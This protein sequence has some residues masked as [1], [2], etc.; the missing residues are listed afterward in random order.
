MGL[1]C[2]LQWSDPVKNISSKVLGV[3]N[4][5][6]LSPSL[7]GFITLKKGR[8]ILPKLDSFQNSH[9][10]LTVLYDQCLVEPR[11]HCGSVSV[12]QSVSLFNV[13]FLYLDSDMIYF[14]FWKTS[15]RIQITV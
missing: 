5:A 13:L 12:P 8:T 1:S 4:I 15:S 10:P 3:K 7:E 11:S 2:I 9:P 6:R 14:V